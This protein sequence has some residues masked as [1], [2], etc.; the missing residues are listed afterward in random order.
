MTKNH[1]KIDTG[2]LSIFELIE[3]AEAARKQLNPSSLA[4]KYD[5]DKRIRALLSES[6]KASPRSRYEVAARISEMTGRSISKEQ[7]DS[8]TAESKE[9]HRFPLVYLPAFVLACGDM[10]T[11]RELSELCGGHYIESED[12]LRLE[13]GKIDEQKR[14]LAKREKAVKDFLSSL[15]GRK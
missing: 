14:E 2:Q 8:W 15:K 10:R 11:I 6:L 13:L 5:L 7:L 3:H 1:K 12:A 9:N 4:G